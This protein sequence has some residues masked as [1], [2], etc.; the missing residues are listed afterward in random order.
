MASFLSRALG[1]FSEACVK[2]DQPEVYYRGKKWKYSINFLQ[3]L[4]ASFAQTTNTCVHSDLPVCSYPILMW[5][6]GGD[7]KETQPGNERRY[8][9]KSHNRLTKI[10]V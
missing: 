5:T 4:A 6:R 1:N 10:V 2:N 8:S 3:K 9:Q 7:T